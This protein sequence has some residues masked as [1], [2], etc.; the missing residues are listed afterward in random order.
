M[1]LLI[2]CQSLLLRSNLQL[3]I[4]TW[5]EKTD[6]CMVNH[7]IVS[8]NASTRTS[9]KTRKV[10]IVWLLLANRCIPSPLAP[11]PVM[12]LNDR[13]DFYISVTHAQFE[14]LNDD[15]FCGTLDP[16]EKAL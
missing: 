3:E 11:R 5:R 16:V 2:G 12:T 14:E 9:V 15:L 6:S 13:I 7:F 10:S 1:I 8:L 4:P